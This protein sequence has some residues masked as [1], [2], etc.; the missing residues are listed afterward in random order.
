[1][2]IVERKYI[3][4]N[5]GF[6]QTKE[7]EKILLSHDITLPDLLVLIHAKKSSSVT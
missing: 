1:M 6:H 4:K 3:Q 7:L 2:D 5:N